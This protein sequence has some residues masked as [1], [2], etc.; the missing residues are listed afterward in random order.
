LH[1]I[2]FGSL[3]GQ[4]GMIEGQLSQSLFSLEYLGH[5]GISLLF[6]CHLLIYQSL[7]ASGHIQHAHQC[8]NGINK[9]RLDWFKLNGLELPL[10]PGLEE[11]ELRKM[12]HQNDSL[13][14][15][16]LFKDRMYIALSLFS[17]VFTA[18]L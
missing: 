7:F 16:N 18:F 4:P 6:D 11:E 10:W 9:G 3:L 2:R 15:P 12:D 13:S 17:I 14:P 8:I 5:G 1:F